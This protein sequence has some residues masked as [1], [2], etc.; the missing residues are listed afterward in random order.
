MPDD[1]HQPGRLSLETGNI[2]LCGLIGSGKTTVGEKLAARMGWPFIDQDAVLTAEAGCDLHEM[3]A[4]D[5]WLGFRQREYDLIK[6][7]ADM[8]R[9]VIGLGGGTVRYAWNVD[10]LSGTGPVILLTADLR[11]LAERVRAADRPRVNPGTSL[12]EDLRLMWSEHEARYLNA[13]SLVYATDRGLTPD[14]EAGEI[15][16]MLRT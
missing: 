6:R 15:L 8:K 1:P 4:R 2:Y 16:S 11:V 12:E 7:F 9:T 5:G 13:A 10:R 3:V 14:E